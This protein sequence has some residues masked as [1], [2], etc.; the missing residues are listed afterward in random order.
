M[1][2]L[3]RAEAQTRAR[4]LD[5]RSYSID[6]DLT[7]GGEVF[8]CATRVRFGCAEPGGS[9]F[10]EIKPEALRRAVLN[11][12]ELDP[13]ALAENRLP[14]DDLAADNELVVEAEMRYSHTGE[15]MHRFTDPVDGETYLYSA[16][17]LDEAQRVFAAFDQPDLKAV[18]EV[19]VTAPEDWTVL[20]NGVGEQ[21]RPGRW[22]F[23][24]TPPISTYL[25]AVVAGPYHAVRSEHDG[26]P[27]GLYCRRSLARHLEDDAEEI[28]RITRRCFDRYHEIFDERYPFGSYDQAFVP[29][30][31]WGAM[32]NPGCVTFRDEFVF[33]SAVTDTQREERAIVIAHE[34][35]H[36]WFGDLV[37]MRW[38]DDLWLN[39]SFAEYM[40]QQIISE[41]TRFEQTW[42]AFGVRRKSWGYDA[43]QRANTHPVAP[44]RVDDTAEALL[45]FDGISYAKGASAV[46]QLVAWLGR[47]AFLAGINEHFSR[48][49]YGNATLA[50]FLDALASASGRDV[51]GWAE[52][53]LRTTGVDTLRPEAESADVRRPHRIRAGLY[54]R[55]G[56]GGL[57][58]R[59][60]VP[61]DVEQGHKGTLIAPEPRPD[62]LLLNDGDLTYA[63]V[64]FDEGSWHAVTESL[65]TVEA[66]LSRAVLWT[67][68]RDM[69]RDAELPASA[70][71]ELVVRHLP[72]EPVVAI[73]ETVLEFSRHQVADRY[74]PPERRADALAELTGVCRRIL[75]RTEDGSDEGLRLTAVRGMIACAQGPRAVAEL[76][77]WLEAD[78]VPGGP[79]LDPAL[80]WKVLLR[81]CV[82]GE[83]GEDR[84]AAELERDP[85]ATGHEGA[86]RCRA[87]LPD[88]DAKAAAWRALFRE[89]ELS[90]YLLTA[91]AEGFWQPEQR[92]L[93]AAWV[94]LY[95][96]EALAATER[97]GQAVGRVLGRFGFP[98]HAVEPD[99]LRAGEAH[100]KDNEVPPSLRR[101][102]EDQ[103]DDLRRALRARHAAV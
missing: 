78:S 30:F 44:E 72:N 29:E 37:T 48:H 49:R 82:L 67:A 6:V 90:N 2:A 74:L 27:L 89:D 66:P 91:T 61:L 99:L 5:V 16:C 80:R 25:A 15:G 86:A 23:T 92:E 17:A 13:A 85:S 4:L 65:G 73:V 26:I 70:F 11:G 47:D 60:V 8:G 43:D 36:M 40:G 59:E 24:A 103:L 35:A 88:R 93:L 1:P 12:R 87:A 28:L 19:A 100:L 102:L 39:E 34:M 56:D 54:D 64:R 81:L 69:V 58:L 10:I 75:R 101:R 33:R 52:S 79:L 3:T 83:A 22:E 63:K 45:N 57:A 41:A 51:H 62:L 50:D 46:R 71:I 18:F 55:D 96:D 94:P 97:R 31:N 98:E 38:W 20:S 21:V 42:T 95:F 32:E 7:R 84:V 14:L 77:D 76:A 9:T 68:A 53:W